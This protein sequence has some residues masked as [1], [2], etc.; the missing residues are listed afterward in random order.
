MVF[1]EPIYPVTTKQQPINKVLLWLLLFHPFFCSSFL[2]HTEGVTLFPVA[3]SLPQTPPVQKAH[4]SNIFSFQ[5]W[6]KTAAYPGRCSELPSSYT[7][8]FV[9][10]H[11]PPWRSRRLHKKEKQL[12]LDQDRPPWQMNGPGD[13]KG[14]MCRRV[15]VKVGGGNEGGWRCSEDI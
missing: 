2:V 11:S 10:R 14:T 8:L 1:Y 3:A 4:P 12:T 7:P 6:K 15:G 9:P 13:S 5:W